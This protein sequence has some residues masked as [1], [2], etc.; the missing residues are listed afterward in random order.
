MNRRYE[1][2][3]IFRAMLRRLGLFWSI[4][5]ACMAILCTILIFTV[6]LDAAYTIGWAVPFIWAGI[7]A[8]ATIW[9]VKKMLRAE[10]I[11]WAEEIAEKS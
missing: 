6:Q 7:W 10:K 11:A 5:S 9:Y 4:G 2:S 1:A 8:I 3:H